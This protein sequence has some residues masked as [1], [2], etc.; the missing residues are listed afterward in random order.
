MKVKDGDKLAKPEDPVKEGY[1]FL[2]W[3]VGDKK[4][5]FNTPITEKE[6]GIVIEARFEKIDTPTPEDKEAPTTPSD[7][8]VIGTTDSTVKIE[9]KASKDNVGVAGYEIFVNGKL[10]DTVNGDVLTAEIIKLVPNTEYTINIVALDK[11]GNKSEAA[12]AKVKTEDAKEPTEPSNPSTPSNPEVNPGAVQ[13]GDAT[14]FAAVF[15]VM[16][17]AA[18]MF[19]GVSVLK[20]RKRK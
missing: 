2:G 19:A 8:K 15:M 1:K 7:L 5:D 10:I 4:F 17:M 16:L 13:T 3:F 18:A 11:A 9:W 6:N 12:S 14:L 20:V